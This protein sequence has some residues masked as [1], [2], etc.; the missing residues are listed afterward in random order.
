MDTLLASDTQKILQLSN[1]EAQRLNSAAIG[2]GHL[3][4]AYLRGSKVRL[5]SIKIRIECDIDAARSHVAKFTDEPAVDSRGKLPFDFE[6]KMAIEQAIQA[7]HG[8]LAFSPHHLLIG[9]LD[10]QESLAN[11]VLT[12]MGIDT[13]DLLAELKATVG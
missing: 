5:D 10:D 3:L 12:A 9:V 11:K 6:A 4:I 7:N 1:Q 8:D 13:T 2:T